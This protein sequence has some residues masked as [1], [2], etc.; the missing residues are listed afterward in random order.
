MNVNFLMNLTHFD[1]IGLLR[2]I[3]ITLGTRIIKFHLKLEIDHFFA[4]FPLS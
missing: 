3:F 4:P 1:E 2:K